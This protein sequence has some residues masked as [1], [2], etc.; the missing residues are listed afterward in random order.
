MEKDMFLFMMLGRVHHGTHGLMSLMVYIPM[1]L[2]H[3]LQAS[4]ASHGPSRA[5]QSPSHAPKCRQRRL[6]QGSPAGE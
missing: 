5:G 4:W 1:V 3:P 2:H 6:W